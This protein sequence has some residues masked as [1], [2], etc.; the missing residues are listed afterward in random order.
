MIFITMEL[1]L[2]SYWKATPLFGIQNRTHNKGLVSNA[3][4]GT[5]DDYFFS[6][7]D[8]Y[9]DKYYV[10]TMSFG[11]SLRIILAMMILAK[12]R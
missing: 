5:K 3:R 6:M 2:L 9:L 7:Q 12:K 8:H 11:N 4:L 1:T 10:K